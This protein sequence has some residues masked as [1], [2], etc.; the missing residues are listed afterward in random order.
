[1][2]EFLEY[3]KIAEGMGK[4]AEE[5][6]NLQDRLDDLNREITEL[7]NKEKE[8]KAVPDKVET[9]QKR[10]GKLQ[11]EIEKQNAIK[12]KIESPEEISKL[13]NFI[14]QKELAAKVL[15]YF[16]TLYSEQ[17][18][19]ISVEGMKVKVN[20]LKIS[21]KYNELLQQ[22]QAYL[23]GH[24][25]AHIQTITKLVVDAVL[26]SSNVLSI[27][28]KESVEIIT[29]AASKRTEIAQSEIHK[30]ILEDLDI[31]DAE[32]YIANE[33]LH[34]TLSKL[35]I[36]ED[37][38]IEV[39]TRLLRD[40]HQLSCKQIDRY[41]NELFYG[42]VY[43][44]ENTDTWYCDNLVQK[45]GEV[46]KKA[47]AR[48]EEITDA[49]KKGLANRLQMNTSQKAMSI[50]DILS[51]SMQRQKVAS[52]SHAFFKSMQILERIA[53][54]ERSHK[55]KIQK[56]IIEKIQEHFELPSGLS[57]HV[58]MQR[59]ALRL[60]DSQAVLGIISLAPLHLAKTEKEEINNG[61]VQ[62][63]G[64][65]EEYFVDIVDESFSH[66][67]LCTKVDRI[68][69]LST[70]VTRT[71]SM[72]NNIFIEIIDRIFTD[73]LLFHIKTM[74][75]SRILRDAY[76]TIQSDLEEADIKHWAELLQ[77]LLQITGEFGEAVDFYC[78]I[79][80]LHDIFWYAGVA[81]DFIEEC[82]GAL[83]TLDSELMHDLIPYVFTDQN[84]ARILLNNFQKK[85]K[86]E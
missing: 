71:I 67:I 68:D 17:S 56:A 1:M 47:E 23:P 72:V 45:I 59:C 25:N 24:F 79:K 63:F 8:I 13:R 55:E 26:L 70:N 20:R 66:L 5:I 69:F 49:Q 14:N 80:G 44:I 39:K 36:F 52:I 57:E 28:H 10:L 12:R 22:V 31:Q 58:E 53:T 11:E 18:T 74:F 81:T 61:I 7:L 65:K 35:A 84:V 27:V 60:A 6:R 21:L 50:L 78:Q 19:V 15:E 85:D 32:S 43:H 48:A 16:S 38:L 82:E 37:I 51:E 41:N 30:Q 9:Y 86:K 40:L 29:Y 76:Y 2:D 34:G 3:L 46:S 33:K 42:T 83:K 4:E 64:Q 75:Y 62:I 54:T 77:S 73:S